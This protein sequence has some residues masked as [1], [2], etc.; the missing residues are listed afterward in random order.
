MV[1]SDPQF[2]R[3]IAESALR[4]A[5]RDIDWFIKVRDMLD[6]K[7]GGEPTGS[8]EDPVNFNLSVKFTDSSFAD[9][10]KSGY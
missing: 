1:D 8:V 10:G 5:A 4:H 9:C 3:K 2:A 7:P 6:G